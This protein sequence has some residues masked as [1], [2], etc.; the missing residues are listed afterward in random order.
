[1]NTISL[2]STLIC[3]FAIYRITKKHFFSDSPLQSYIYYSYIAFYITHIIAL[4]FSITT[5]TLF[6]FST[7]IS[8]YYN[9][10]RIFFGLEFL[11]FV[12]SWVIFDTILFLRLYFTFNYTVYHISKQCTTLSIIFICFIF[13][14]FFPGFTF[15]LIY[16]LSFVT[17]ILFSFGFLCLII[18]SQILVFMFVRKLFEI[19]LRSL[20]NNIGIGAQSP[21]SRT[22]VLSTSS[23]KSAMSL[24]V[25]DSAEETPDPAAI[26]RRL[27]I[28]VV[29]AN[30]LQLMTK[31]TLLA[32]LS[33]VSSYVAFLTCIVWIV[34]GGDNGSIVDVVLVSII[35]IS[36]YT[37]SFMNVISVTF[38]FIMFEKQYQF[39]CV[40]CDTKLHGCCFNLVDRH[41]EGKS[42]IEKSDLIQHMTERESTERQMR[43]I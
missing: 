39:L 9:L 37:H 34:S 16:D 19:N 24:E 14:L 7:N 1:M 12:S 4:P 15:Y 22:N 17:V 13:L 30:E 6:C 32:L 41:F 29:C 35:G 42:E 10:E 2:S 28:D 21:R 3:I 11:C 5:D 38:A 8:K 31:Y 20:I 40:C 33:I 26:R 25:V 23:A 36:L 27:T 43:E 18:F